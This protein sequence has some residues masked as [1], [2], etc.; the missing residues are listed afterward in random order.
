MAVKI[1]EMIFRIARLGNLRSAAFSGEI[2]LLPGRAGS[3]YARRSIAQHDQAKIGRRRSGRTIQPSPSAFRRLP[4]LIDSAVNAVDL[5]D[6][7]ALAGNKAQ[8]DR[9]VRLAARGV[10]RQ[11]P[12]VSQMRRWRSVRITDVPRGNSLKMNTIRTSTHIWGLSGEMILLTVAGD[13][14]FW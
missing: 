5:I 12:A 11:W 2:G 8:G 13:L 14:S 9:F 10:N 7:V 6:P 3:A 1:I 4:K